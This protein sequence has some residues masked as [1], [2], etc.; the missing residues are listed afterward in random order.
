ML[1]LSPIRTV[2]IFIIDMF[3]L[4]GIDL[5]RSHN[6]FVKVSYPLI[7][8]EIPPVQLA[9]NN[10]LS[11]ENDFFFIQIGAND[12][13]RA[14]PIRKLVLRHHLKGILVEP[15]DDFYQELKYNYQSEEQLIFEN[16][17]IAATHNDILLYRFN[18]DAPVP[19]YAHGMATTEKETI[20]RLAS[21][22]KMDDQVEEIRVKSMTYKDLLLKH[23][24]DSVSLLQIDTEGY[25]FEIIKMVIDG[26]SLP[27]VINYE[28]DRL[29]PEDR[30]ESY[31]MLTEKGYH[32]IHDRWDTLAIL[33]DE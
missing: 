26:G 21:K 19:D 31:K 33:I 7:G 9:V 4:F 25:D 24:V 18:H 10:L 6:G 28:F 11:E 5:S 8:N 32:F 13:I 20:T 29:T 14:D 3:K 30:L 2:K 22:W 17:A 27:S 12:G 23:D 15:L 16:V 1:S